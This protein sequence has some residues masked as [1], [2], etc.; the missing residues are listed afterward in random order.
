[1]RTETFGVMLILRIMDLMHCQVTGTS[2][3]FRA[4]RLLATAQ[5]S[6]TYQQTNFRQAG[7][8]YRLAWNHEHQSDNKEF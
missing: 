4:I 8:I 7:E 5:A 3:P 2:F 6:H 1:M